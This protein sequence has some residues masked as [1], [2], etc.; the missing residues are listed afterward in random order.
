[1]GA[2]TGPGAIAQ[3]GERLHGMQEVAG[4][5]PASST[6]GK[7]RSVG[8]FCCS[9]SV[10]SI[11]SCT[12]S[13]E[14]VPIGAHSRPSTSARRRSRSVRDGPGSARISP[15][16]AR[17]RR[18]RHRYLQGAKRRA[19]AARGARTAR[20]LDA[21]AGRGLHAHS[22]D[23]AFTIA[24]VAV[25]VAPRASRKASPGWSWPTP[26]PGRTGRDVAG[27]LP[28]AGT[29]AMSRRRNLPFAA[30]G[31]RLSGSPARRPPLPS[32]RWVA[33]CECRAP[34]ARSAA[35]AQLSCAA[36]PP[37]RSSRRR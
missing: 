4:S 34:S 8:A 19:S 36:L 3:L 35:L 6:S 5:S 32:M 23:K 29:G 9:G 27:S 28:A 20:V 10:A 1:M 22:E 11:A 14:L 33:R 7:P 24:T 15:V 13:A 12:A 21:V 16:A 18:H 25:G 2:A 30:R 26:G 37:S 17:R 31:A